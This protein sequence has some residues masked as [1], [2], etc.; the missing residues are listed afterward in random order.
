MVSKRVVKKSNGAKPPWLTKELK[1]NRKL[2]PD[3]LSSILG[4][5]LAVAIKKYC[6]R[7]M[8]NLHF[9]TLINYDN[10]IFF[11]IFLFFR[12]FFKKICHIILE[13][14]F[15]LFLNTIKSSLLQNQ[16]RVS[17]Q[18]SDVNV[19]D[20]WFTSIHPKAN[21]SKASGA[22]KEELQMMKKCNKAEWMNECIYLLRLKCKVRS[23]IDNK[24][25]WIM[26]ELWEGKKNMA[27]HPIMMVLVFESPKHVTYMVLSFLMG[28]YLIL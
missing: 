15:V 6:P 10:S 25:P 13:E 3:H 26:S 12:W 27:H 19:G 28:F 16:K 20:G 1:P 24:N 11:F 17:P 21:W 7:F 8:L 14:N 22:T 5:W 18:T 23:A 9:K 2:F 4:C